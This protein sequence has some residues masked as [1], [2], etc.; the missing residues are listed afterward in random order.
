MGPFLFLSQ[1]WYRSCGHPRRT[2]SVVMSLAGLAHGLI[3][4][5]Y[6]TYVKL[7]RPA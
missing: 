5:A 1:H 6:G 3:V 4:S 2:V 7:T